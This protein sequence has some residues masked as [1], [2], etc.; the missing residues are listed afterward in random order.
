MVS[1]VQY[2]E[3][4]AEVQSLKARAEK[5]LG[6]ALPATISQSLPSSVHKNDGNQRLHRQAS[7]RLSDTSPEP[8]KERQREAWKL[9]QRKHRRKQQ[10]LKGGTA[11]PVEAKPSELPD[12][13]IVTDWSDCCYQNIGSLDM[14]SMM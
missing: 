11:A 4:L 5:Y 14:G 8:Q 10:K 3:L 2:E 9:R 6:L 7:A 12:H 1:D 13:I